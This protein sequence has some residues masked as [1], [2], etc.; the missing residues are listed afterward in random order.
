MSEAP[1]RV[2]PV[3]CC[4]FT[5]FYFYLALFFN[6]EFLLKHS[7]SGVFGWLI[8]TKMPSWT[9]PLG[10]LAQFQTNTSSYTSSVSGITHD[11]GWKDRPGASQTDRNHVS[12]TFYPT[13]STPDVCL[14]NQVP[15]NGIHSP[16]P[17][18]PSDIWLALIQVSFNFTA[19]EHLNSGTM[20]QDVAMMK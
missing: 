20:E 17:W 6:S 9:W 4:S 12:S 2:S 14:F 11:F 7:G 18:H 19:V 10:L 1:S 3:G 16:T 8:D 15:G 13:P 5:F